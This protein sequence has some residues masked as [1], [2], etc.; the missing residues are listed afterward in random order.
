MFGTKKIAVVKDY[1][2]ET[3][4]DLRTGEKSATGLPVSNVMY[5]LTEDQNVTVVR[6]SGTEPKVKVYV[7]AN[8]KDK[9]AAQE[10]ADTCTAGIKALLNA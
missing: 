7:L 1:L 8:G 4:L 6:P 2:T 9:A 3:V 5:Y 10:N